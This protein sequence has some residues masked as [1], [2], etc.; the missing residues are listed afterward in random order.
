VLVLTLT[1][2]LILV[3]VL[4]A[5]LLVLRSSASAGA[6]KTDR[7]EQFD[8]DLSKFFSYTWNGW[9]SAGPDDMAKRPGCLRHEPH[10]DKASA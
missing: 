9:A 4:P 3:L 10:R 1:L 7:S 5:W 8:A 6:G 2:I